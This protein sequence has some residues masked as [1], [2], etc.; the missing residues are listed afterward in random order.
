MMAWKVM[1]HGSNGSIVLIRDAKRKENIKK[2][3]RRWFALAGKK[4]TPSASLGAPPEAMETTTG[5][6]A[7]SSTGMEGA[8]TPVVGLT[9]EGYVVDLE[10]VMLSQGDDDNDVYCKRYHTTLE[11][12]TDRSTARV[13]QKKDHE[14]QEK[15]HAAM[16]Y[17]EAQLQKEVEECQKQEEE[18]VLLDQEEEAVEERRRKSE[19]KQK[20]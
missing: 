2:Q 18:R 15:E 3:E 1:V 16:Q 19:E 11:D 6:I 14:K 8:V 7:A 17:P 12:R 9:I 5:M 20:A 13:K 10:V 4:S